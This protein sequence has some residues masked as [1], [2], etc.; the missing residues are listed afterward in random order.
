MLAR[1]LESRSVSISDLGT[2]EPACTSDK[3]HLDFST[4]LERTGSLWLQC[5][6]FWNAL[7]PNSR[8]ALWCSEGVSQPLNPW[9]WRAAASIHC[10]SLHLSLQECLDKFGDSLQE[11][12]N[13][14]MVR[15][16]FLLSSCVLMTTFLKALIMVS[17]VWLTWHCTKVGSTKEVFSG[18]SPCSL[19]SLESSK[20]LGA[21]VA[22]CNRIE[23][24]ELW[25]CYSQWSILM[26]HIC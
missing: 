2:W 18:S 1:L 14:H 26:H 16:S 17:W 7:L 13:Y 20:G 10:Q 6:A 21:I 15:C 11:M 12:I 4:E 25:L 23:L 22:F 3:W 9:E 5:Q 24:D 8:V 19:C